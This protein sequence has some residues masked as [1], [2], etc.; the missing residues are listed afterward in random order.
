MDFMSDRLFD[1]QTFRKLTV[2]DCHTR[3]ALSTA[4]TTNF[5]AYQV[6]EELDRLIRLRGKQR[7]IRVDNGPEFSGRML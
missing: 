7:S 4:S 2:V 6:V 5:R 3:E 1:G